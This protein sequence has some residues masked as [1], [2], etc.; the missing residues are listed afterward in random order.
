MPGCVV[1]IVWWRNIGRAIGVEDHHIARAQLHRRDVDVE[2]VDDAEQRAGAAER[3]DALRTDEDR[4][5][6]TATGDREAARAL[7]P[8][9]AIVA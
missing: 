3:G 7:R 2:V 6:M 5:G 1:E 4:Q 9:G 8:L